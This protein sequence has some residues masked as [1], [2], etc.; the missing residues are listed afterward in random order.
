M[1]VPDFQSLMLPVL[2]IVSEAGPIAAPDLRA[3][4]AERLSLSD[5]DLA[6]RSSSGHHTIFGN[7]V[8]WANVYLQRAGLIKVVR[9]GVYAI[10]DTGTAVLE[11]KVNSID[12]EYLEEFAGYAEWRKRAA[13]PEEIE[14]AASAQA[15]TP[16]TPATNPE[17]QI[18]KS[19]RELTTVVEAELLDRL[20]ATT[21]A[22]FEQIIIDLLVAMGYG[23][24][25]AEMG[26]AIGRSGDNGVDGVIREDKLG[27][28][29]VFIQAKRYAA[30][31][32][33]GASEV[34]DF[35]GSLD[36]HRAAK[37]IFVTTSTFPKSAYDVVMRAS[38]RVVLIDGEELAHLMVA[39]GVGVRVKTRYEINE[40]DD[41]YFVN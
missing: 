41:D 16:V 26:K 2:Q 1:A 18:E 32:T 35:V 28:D 40:L 34:R 31:N 39:H 22:Q 30:D 27:L 15:T 8:A 36:M 21:P 3:R 19:H 25:R 12:L 10:S 23:G 4:V 5:D 24:G 37:G 38:K 7:R 17:E 11:R 29:V 9:R 14:S 6:E 33:V 13:R 20:R